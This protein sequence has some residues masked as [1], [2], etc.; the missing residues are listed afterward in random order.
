VTTQ[1]H[2]KE[3]AVIEELI[4]STRLKKK[5]TEENKTPHGATAAARGF[6]EGA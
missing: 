3:W 2:R 6:P 1:R 5:K 4:I